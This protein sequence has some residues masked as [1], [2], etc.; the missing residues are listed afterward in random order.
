MFK[1]ALGTVVWV[2]WDSYSQ[3]Q[4]ELSINSQKDTVRRKG[5]SGCGDSSYDYEMWEENT[6]QLISLPLCLSW[7]MT[8]IGISL[9]TGGDSLKCELTG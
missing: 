1:E 4:Q 2:A 6:G 9:G 3:F 5:R 8:L 7:K